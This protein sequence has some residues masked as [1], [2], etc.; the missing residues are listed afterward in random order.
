[1]NLRQCLWCAVSALAVMVGIAAYSHFSSVGVADTTAATAGPK[2]AEPL[3][4]RQVVLFNS[5]LGYFQREGDVTGNA[6]ID[7]SFPAAEIN[8]L[9]KSLLLQDA[10]GKIG[11][12]NYDSSDPIDKILRSF[13]L[14]LTAILAGDAK[15]LELDALRIE[16]AEDVVVRL[17]EQRR[18]VGEG[19]VLGEPARIGVAVR[20]DDRQVADAGIEAARDSACHRFGR[21]KTIVVQQ[22]RWRFLYRAGP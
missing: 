17:D 4:I 13:A 20:R 2:V 3:P 18:R 21:Q 7:L 1:M 9:L 6:R 10:K 19:L 8:D 22:H 14:D 11:T 5:G 15:L 16:H 12:V